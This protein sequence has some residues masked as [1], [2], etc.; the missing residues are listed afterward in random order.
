MFGSGVTERPV[1]S[2]GTRKSCGVPPSSALTS[3]RVAALSHGT[4]HFAPSSTKSPPSRLRLR[5][6]AEGVGAEAGL[7]QGERARHEGVA[8]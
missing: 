3:T 4:W 8:A 2:R 7:E 1:A 6:R 5:A